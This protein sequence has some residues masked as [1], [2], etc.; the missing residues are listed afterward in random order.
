LSTINTTLQNKA[1]ANELNEVKSVVEDNTKALI[2]KV[3]KVDYMREITRLDSG[4][5]SRKDIAVVR[6]EIDM[7]QQ[8][9]FRELVSDK[10]GLKEFKRFT[11][12]LQAE[13]KRILK[14]KV[15]AKE[16]GIHVAKIAA[17]Y[18]T[19]E[20]GQSLVDK[21]MSAL[22]ISIDHVQESLGHLLGPHHG[23]L[24]FSRPVSPILASSENMLPSSNHTHHENFVANVTTTEI[25]SKPPSPIAPKRLTARELDFSRS[26]T[27]SSPPRRSIQSAMSF[28]A[29]SSLSSNKPIGR[30]RS[31]SHSINISNSTSNSTMQ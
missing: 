19:K 11:E 6:D 27:R 23:V 2:E 3:D 24:T 25:P 17:D 29:N 9:Q 15:D 22:R 7:D 1:S 18:L 30:K 31:G 26:P 28:L 10:V 21:K 14:S 16:F 4:K 8:H 20:E 12:S 5:L 13:V